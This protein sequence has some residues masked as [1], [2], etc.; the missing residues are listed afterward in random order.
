MLT[1]SKCGETTGEDTHRYCDQC[2]QELAQ[3]PPATEATEAAEAPEAPHGREP[4][5][6]QARDNYSRTFREA[7]DSGIV[8]PD[9]RRTLEAEREHLGLSPKEAAIAEVE[10]TDEMTGRAPADETAPAAPVLL[11]MDRGRIYVERY[12]GVLG[13]RLSNRSGRRLEDVRLSVSGP[14]LGGAEDERLVLGP[15][16][17]KRPVRISIVPELAGEQVC[18]ITLKFRLDAADHT[19]TA[20]PIL[21]ALAREEN[22]SVI[23]QR[24]DVHQVVGEDAEKVGFGQMISNDVKMAIE[25]GSI[26]TT[27]DLLMQPQVESWQPVRLTPVETGV[28]HVVETLAARRPWLGRASLMWTE[29]GVQARM[30]LLGKDRVRM[31]RKRGD[32]EIVLRLHP[33]SAQNDRLTRQISGQRP[34]L[35]IALKDDGLWL[36]DHETSNGTRV[37]GTKVNGKVK[38]RLDGASEVDVAGA[39]TLRV[40]P[41]GDGPAGKNVDPR[42]YEALGKPDALWEAAEAVGLRSVLIERLNNLAREERYLLVYRWAECGPGTGAELRP[43]KG[44]GEDAEFRI[45]RLGGKLW[46]ENPSGRP[47]IAV[48]DVRVPSSHAFPLTA[49]LQMR[50]GEADVRVDGFEQVGF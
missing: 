8:S 10:T 32:N 16:E 12:M 48:G 25:R 43:P 36:I 23:L 38:L 40:L 39:L 13:F 17:Q 35:S 45:I 27:N 9:D 42:K 49:G 2:G 50:L 1:C 5:R 15:D 33:R 34:H 31:G 44:S 26:R 7:M 6:Q 14:R 24:Q 47:T 20:Q 19:W 11:E 30:L 29:D 37:N 3:G 4:P 21:L 41:H 46:V 28:V 18:T 22:P